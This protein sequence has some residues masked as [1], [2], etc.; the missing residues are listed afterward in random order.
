MSTNKAKVLTTTFATTLFLVGCGG[1]NGE[2]TGSGERSTETKTAESAFEEWGL[3]ELAPGTDPTASAG[4]V[5][6]LAARTAP[7]AATQVFRFY[8]TLTQAHFFTSSVTERDA[9]RATAPHMQYDGPAYF[10]ASHS[11]TALQPVY[12]F[13]N[14]RN[15]VHFYTI[16]ENEKAQIL[17][18]F[19]QFVLEGVA[20]RASATPGVGLMPLHRFYLA[21]QGFHF[22]STNEQEVASIRANLPQYIYE[23]VSYYVPNPNPSAILASP[24]DGLLTWN[25]PSDISVLISGPFGAPLSGAPSCTS[26][27]STKASVTSDCSRATVK[28]LD[29]TG[30]VMVSGGGYTVPLPLK[31]TPQRHWSGRHGGTDGYGL[32]VTPDGRALIWSGSHSAYNQ[33]LAQGLTRPQQPYVTYPIAI[34]NSA[35]TGALTS[36]VQ[37]SGGNGGALALDRS[38]SLWTWGDNHLCAGGIGV[39][40]PGEFLLPVRVRGVNGSPALT[41]VVQAERSASNSVAL[42]DDGRVVYWGSPPMPGATDKQCLPALVPSPGGVGGLSEIV[43]VSAGV[44]YSLALTQSGKVYA[45]GRDGGIGLLGSGTLITSTAPR[46]P[47]TVKKS[48]GNDLDNIVQVSAGHSNGMALDASG[49][50]WI[51]GAGETIG[52]GSSGTQQAVPHAVP[53]AGLGQIAMVA[54]GGFHNMALDDQG[55]IWTWATHGNTGTL[56][57]GENNPRGPSELARVPGLVVNESGA[58]HLNGVLSIAASYNG[59]SALMPDG[60][61]LNWGTNFYAALGQG[62]DIGAGGG[63]WLATN[64]YFPV[65]LRNE[66]NSGSLALSPAAYPNRLR[67]A[68]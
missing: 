59:G 50:V 54:A 34:R 27:D 41:Q 17:A 11:E 64:D 5:A 39:Q 55:R 43:Q 23:G 15:G 20:Y 14:T 3:A 19:P 61:V 68:R 31:S 18:N 56:G 62:V 25:I 29:A 57:D 12:R 37:S 30:V 1:G 63:N 22:Y 8:N 49:T 13:L 9:V 67:R 28:R 46:L 47:N 58:G 21:G 60:R 16:S 65:P 40:T 35:G 53:V 33:V 66:T 2:G 52:T 24:P 7:I 48:D 36:I 51:W 44:H 4:P 6:K 42:L 38:G 10:A 45:F 32:V 26:N